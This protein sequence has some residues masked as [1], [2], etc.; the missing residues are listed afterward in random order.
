M[1]LLMLIMIAFAVIVGVCVFYA[2]WEMT[3]DAENVADIADA[4]DPAV[5]TPEQVP[6]AEA[7]EKK[8]PGRS[9]ESKDPPGS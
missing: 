4:A 5:K 8:E 2:A 7:A 1:N 6:V 3:S 9:K